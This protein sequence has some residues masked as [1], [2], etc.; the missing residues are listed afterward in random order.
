M[1]KHKGESLDPDGHPYDYIVIIDAGSKGSRANV[2]RTR[3]FNNNKTKNQV[4]DWKDESVSTTTSDSEKSKKKHKSD[5]QQSNDPP[6]TD[7]PEIISM[8]AK[9]VKKIKPGIASFVDNTKK[10]KKSYMGKLLKDVLKYIPND[11]VHRTPIFLHAT[12]GMRLLKPEDQN[13][14]LGEI[15]SYI[16]D[17]FDFYLPDCNSHINSISGEIE[18]LYSWIGVNYKYGVLNAALESRKQSFGILDMGGV[19][20]QIALEPNITDS[21]NNNTDYLFKVHLNYLDPSNESKNSFNVFSESFLGGMNQIHTKY[22]QLLISQ[23]ETTDPCL[24]KNY[25]TT[26]ESTSSETGYE[27]EIPITGT[28]DFETCVTSLNSLLT[29]ITSTK[30]CNLTSSTSSVSSCLLTDSMPYLNF[31]IERF[32]GINGFYSN[33][34]NFMNYQEFYSKTKKTCSSH[35]TDLLNSENDEKTSEICFKSSW[36]I[37]VLHNGLGFPRYGIDTKQDLEQEEISVFDDSFKI[38]DEFSWTLGRAVLYSY[39]EA[40]QA[41]QISSL[42]NS[43]DTLKIGFIEPISNVFH[44]G[45]EIPGI[46]SRPDY[47]KGYSSKSKVHDDDDH[48]DDT[49]DEDDDDDDWDDVL[50]EHR[51]WGSLLFLLML[52]VVGYLMLGKTKRKNIIDTVKRLYHEKFRSRY[53]PVDHDINDLEIDD[54]TPRNEEDEDNQDNRHRRSDSFDV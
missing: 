21:D 39:Y 47:I 37:N 14:I 24:P 32:I 34:M 31:N 52:L 1:G 42:G 43:N 49:D 13:L 48:D 5:K 53:L 2:Y 7:Y 10:L 19:S 26:I 27:E 11:Q 29:T 45:G 41:Q 44:Y 8:N 30:S 35:Y 12:G 36:I 18:G 20:S 40:A 4:R 28:G 25:V 9:H 33:L 17:K 6:I 15:C 38:L 16:Q 50:E 3:R 46:S 54:L 23:N 22:D 51:L